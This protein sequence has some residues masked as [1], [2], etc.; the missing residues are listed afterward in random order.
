MLPPSC[1]VF[2]IYSWLPHMISSKDNIFFSTIGSPN[3]KIFMTQPNSKHILSYWASNKMLVSW[4]CYLPDYLP[5]GH[6]NQNRIN[7]ASF[8]IFLYFSATEFINRERKITKRKKS[9]CS[10]TYTVV[11]WIFCIYNFCMLFSK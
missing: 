9:Y 10:L 5:V 8:Y 2:Q 7:F 1:S 11:L 3:Q 6:L 4:I